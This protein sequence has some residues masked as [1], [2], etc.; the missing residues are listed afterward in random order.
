[1]LFSTEKR[2]KSVL[3]EMAYL[4]IDEGTNSEV[5]GLSLFKVYERPSND[6]YMISLEDAIQFCHENAMEFDPFISKVC[7]LNR[8]C[9]SD[10]CYSVHP[11][12]IYLDEEAVTR[13]NTLVNEGKEVYCKVDSNPLM[14]AFG[15]KLQE[16][17]ETDNSEVIVDLVNEGFFDSILSGAKRGI[18]QGARDTGLGVLSVGG[19][20]VANSISAGVK[21]AG[22]GVAQRRLDNL[23]PT[24]KIQD[25]ARAHGVNGEG[26]DMIGD[27]VNG[28]KRDLASTVGAAASGGSGAVMDKLRGMLDQ[29]GQKIGFFTR[30]LASGDIDQNKRSFF[31][32]G[33]DALNKLKDAI[34]NRIRGIKK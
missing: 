26:L 5:E 27:F 29:V 4:P 2:S 7:E 15:N 30:K 22:Q 14:E 17:V 23:A 9:E 28:M 31:Q 33:L 19:N 3:E 12:S 18:S 24:Q 8:I 10:V 21:S 13:F 25:F 34:M 16:L 11:S 6:Q 1:M 20:A 32:K